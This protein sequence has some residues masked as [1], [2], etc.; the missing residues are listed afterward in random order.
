MKFTINWLK[1]HLDT[2]KSEQQ[3]TDALN[4]IG[5]EVES[6]EPIKNELSNCVVAR[7][8]KAAAS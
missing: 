6:V 4:K 1:D 3:I 5:L 2:K 8:I 7:I